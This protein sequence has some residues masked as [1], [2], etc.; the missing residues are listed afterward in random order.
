MSWRNGKIV[1]PSRQWESGCPT[2][3]RLFFSGTSPYGRL[4]GETGVVDDARQRRIE[5]AAARGFAVRLCVTARI[6][7]SVASSASPGHT[8]AVPLSL[9]PATLSSVVAGTR[10]FDA[11]LYSAGRAA[12][13]VECRRLSCPLGWYECRDV[14]WVVPMGQTP[15]EVVL[16]RTTYLAHCRRHRSPTLEPASRAL[17]FLVGTARHIH[18]HI[19]SSS[20][21]HGTLLSFFF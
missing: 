13:V 10:S 19:T 1:P 21:P 12:C 8:A 7:T 4:L 6:V 15:N 17:V 5:P 18:A 16:P 14:A 3:R 2:T 20:P 11:A 9:Q